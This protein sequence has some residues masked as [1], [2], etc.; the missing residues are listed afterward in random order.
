MT[1]LSSS[2]LTA[3]ITEMFIQLLQNASGDDYRLLRCRAFE[4]CGIIAVAV[5]KGIVG[6]YLDSLAKELMKTQSE[7]WP[8]RIKSA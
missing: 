4:A 6:E 2:D 7:F 1:D 3:K 8:F 5:G